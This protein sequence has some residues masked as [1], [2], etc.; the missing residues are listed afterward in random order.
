MTKINTAVIGATGY[1]GYELVKILARH[2]NVNIKYLSS[3]SNTGEKYTN[4]HLQLNGILP[5]IYCIADD[6][7]KMSNECDVIF[8]AL[9]HGVSASK[10]NKEILTKTKNQKGFCDY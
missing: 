2:P 4:I 8:L 7:D 10:I 5:D 3:N 6:I 9:P 1:T